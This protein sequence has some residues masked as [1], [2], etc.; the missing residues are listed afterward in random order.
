[1][2]IRTATIA[3]LDAVLDF[4]AEFHANSGLPMR[5]DRAAMGRLVS[6]M[7]E[8][9]VG[10]VLLSDTGVIGGVLSPAYC[11][12]EWLVAVELF[13][14]AK[15]DGLALLRSFEAWAK[16]KNANEVRMSSL[17]HIPRSDE[18][19]KHKGYMPTEISYQKVI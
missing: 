12:P 19:L 1:M 14:W 10:T 9:E 13:W 11:D 4:C 16:E 5:F 3:D 15:R 7:I 18:L 17:A 8:N 2:L 6:G